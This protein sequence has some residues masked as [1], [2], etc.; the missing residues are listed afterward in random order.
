MPWRCDVLVGELF[1]SAPPSRG[2]NACYARLCKG[3]K[4]VQDKVG[5]ERSRRGPVVLLRNELIRHFSVG[6]ECL[7]QDEDARNVPAELSFGF[8]MGVCCGVAVK[9]VSSFG[10]QLSFLMGLG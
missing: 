2:C 3:Q 5:Q 6:V 8:V 4:H 9:K 1:P 10:L 7:P